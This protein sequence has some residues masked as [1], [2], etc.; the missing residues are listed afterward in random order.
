[1]IWQLIKYVMVAVL[2]ILALVFLV[3][4]WI[5]RNKISIM[6]L[7]E[8]VK[9]TWFIRIL[10]IAVLAVGYLAVFS[11]AKG[12][13]NDSYPV[14]SVK[15]NYEEAAKGLNPN[16]TRFNAS[17]IIG[18]D[19]LEEV[20]KKGGF[21]ISVDELAECL[22]LETNYD[23]IE[24]DTED[25][26]KLNIATDYHV[27]FKPGIRQLKIDGVALMN[28]IGSVYRDKFKDTKTE[29]VKILDLD[30][31]EY[32]NTEYHSVAKYLEMQAHKLKHF[33]DTYSYENSNYRSSNG[34][35]FA[36]LSN[37][38]QNYLDVELERYNS[39][40]VENG[41]TGSKESFDTLT[42]Y[43]NKLLTLDYDKN[44]AAYDVRLEA[45]KMYDDQ[46]AK[47]VLVPTKDE[48]FEYYMSRTKIG[49][50]NFA[51]EA[52]HELE[53]ATSLQKKIDENTYAKERVDA[54]E[55]SSAA[56]AKADELGQTLLTELKELGTESSDIINSYIA[57]K[58]KGYL[59]IDFLS[60]SKTGRIG[61]KR[62]LILTA[63]FALLL[64][65]CDIFAY[66][67]LKVK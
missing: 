58:R 25:V 12:K 63:C 52:Q 61:L 11:F 64:F 1:M 60:R 2:V 27:V 35:T 36:A 21:N 19:V 37:K 34:S 51:D 67:N 53:S 40:V 46:M 9:N 59:Q 32:S 39:Y 23:K 54:A 17:E 4:L 8:A 65:G 24:I 16:S 47:I 7:K 44:M 50:D 14:L 43:K 26:D 66:I 55:A 22:S 62:G 18:K 48:D 49:V 45:I 6:S 31:S 33:I 57:D 41:L 10:I 28:L 38:I 30:V 42:D 3:L 20:I 56:F 15:L 29:N 13:Y 5:S